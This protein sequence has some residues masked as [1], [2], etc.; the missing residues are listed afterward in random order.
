MKE[1]E[2]SASN[3]LKITK[4]ALRVHMGEHKFINFTMTILCAR[5]VNI[6]N[7]SSE[8]AELRTL[9]V[10]VVLTRLKGTSILMRSSI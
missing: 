9:G 4:Q 8:D 10:I 7:R 1:E 3:C 2:S 5:F 6:C